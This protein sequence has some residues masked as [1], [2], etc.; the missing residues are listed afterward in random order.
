MNRDVRIRV[1]GKL[2][3]AGEYAVSAGGP[4]LVCAV[5]RY[6]ECSSAEAERTS[7][8]GDGRRWL[9]GGTEVPELG[10]AREALAAARDWLA[11]RGVALAPQAIRI[12]DDL[13]APSGAK[14]GLGGSACTCVGVTAATLAAHGNEIDKELVFK[15]ASV[16]HATA[17]GTIGSAVDVAAATFGKVLFTRRLDVAPLLAVRSSPQ[18][19]ATAVE[20]L[21]LPER[22]TV[23]APAGILLAYSGQSASTALL[24][25]QVERFAGA[26]RAQF[27][28]FMART[29]AAC[30][31]LRRAL[32]AE[33][34]RGI[35][36]AVQTAGGLLESLGEESGASIVTEAHRAIIETARGL[37]VAAKISGA[38]GGD[39]CV[40]LGR[41]EQLEA[42]SGAL[43]A[44]GVLAIHLRIDEEGVRATAAG[45]RPQNV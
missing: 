40:A 44:R 19:F 45:P 15:L 27:A 16:A 39:S 18:R 1:P 30:D 32:A 7:I 20:R 11:G 3:L 28:A 36:E 17:Q 35:L 6:L 42:L 4:A 31:R 33:D 25:K 10:F 14:L 9:E 41:P 29:S 34:A 2:L 12:A 13:R 26:S 43:Q 37:G 38:G 24:V 23:R 22:E 8:E 5:Q 21:E